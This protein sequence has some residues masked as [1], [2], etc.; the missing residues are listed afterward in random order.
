[1]S[2]DWTWARSS[3]ELKRMWKSVNSR[4][5]VYKENAMQK[6]KNKRRQNEQKLKISEVRKNMEIHKQKQKTIWRQKHKENT[7][8]EIW[9]TKMW[10]NKRKR[11]VIEEERK[12]TSRIL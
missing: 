6:K 9:K 11:H 4:K 1:M 12:K 8:E 3:R 2:D 10:D 5:H 7:S